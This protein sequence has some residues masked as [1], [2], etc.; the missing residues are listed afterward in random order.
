MTVPLRSLAVLAVNVVAVLALVVLLSR[1]ALALARALTPSSPRFSLC[2]SATSRATR[3]SPST[4]L[5]AL[6]VRFRP[7]R[8]LSCCRPTDAAE[9]F[10]PRENA[11]EIE[12]AVERVGRS[13]E[14]WVVLTAVVGSPAPEALERVGNKVDARIEE[15]D[16]LGLR[17]VDIV[18]AFV[19]DAPEPD[20]TFARRERSDSDRRVGSGGGTEMVFERLEIEFRCLAKELSASGGPMTASVSAA[21]DTSIGDSAAS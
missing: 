2:R 9:E 14:A 15:P 4:T 12:T 11:R 19:E 18:L 1:L 7:S 6:L 21:Y 5:L 8:S 16:V 17:V 10:P 20:A 3:A 13:G